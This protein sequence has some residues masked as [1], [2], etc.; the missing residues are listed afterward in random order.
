VSDALLITEPIRMEFVRADDGRALFMGT[1]PSQVQDML[2]RF[3]GAKYFEENGL[4]KQEQPASKVPVAPFAIGR[5]PVTNAQYAA[6]VE[7]T[8]HRPPKHFNWDLPPSGKEQHPVVEVSWR[9]AVAF[10]EWLSRATGRSLRLP[11]EVEWEKA[12]R[13]ADGRLWPWGDE[14]DPK[15]ATTRENGPYDTTPVGAY[16]PGGNSPCGAADMAGN[17]WEWCSTK[18]RDDYTTAADD[19]L[20]GDAARVFRGGAFYLPAMFVRCASRRRFDPGSG[21]NGIGFRV[22]V[23]L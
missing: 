6:F 15:R 19:S 16:S 4:F 2:K 17:V 7:A 18:W 8:G 10:T 11:T 14:W 5:Y 1:P 12:A 21:D 20:G 22:A 13:G 23:S 3:D 9:D